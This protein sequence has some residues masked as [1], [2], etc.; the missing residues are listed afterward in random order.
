MEAVPVKDSEAPGGHDVNP[1]LLLSVAGARSRSTASVASVE[2]REP[3]L[4]V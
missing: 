4:P 2:F 1:I 3:V